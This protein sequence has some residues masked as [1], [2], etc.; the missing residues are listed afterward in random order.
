MLYKSNTQQY[1]IYFNRFYHYFI[2]KRKPFMQKFIIAVLCTIPFVSTP[3]YALPINA[4]GAAVASIQ[5]NNS[6]LANDIHSSNEQESD[7]CGAGIVCNMS[8]K[9]TLSGGGVGSVT[10]NNS[11]IQNKIDSRNGTKN[12][13]CTALVCNLG[14]R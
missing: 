8:G 11:T 10:I 13:F 12:R 14:K 1:L 7:F 5:V 2:N 3:S 4:S 6:H 9:N